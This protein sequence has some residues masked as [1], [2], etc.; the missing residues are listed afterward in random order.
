MNCLEGVTV[1]YWPV[2]CIEFQRAIVDQVARNHGTT[3]A[4]VPHSDG[5]LFD[6]QR[7]IDVE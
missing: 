2:L 7:A 5:L 3:I 6:M 4:C 1:Q